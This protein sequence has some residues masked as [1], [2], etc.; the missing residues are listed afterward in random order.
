M[1]ELLRRSDVVLH[2]I[3]IKGLRTDVDASAGLKRSSNEGLYLLTRPTGGEVFKNANDL[4]SSFRSLLKRQEVVYILGFQA[5]GSNPGRFHS[6]K[7]KVKM[8]GATASH[9]SGYY[10]L[11]SAES[12]L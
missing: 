3:D 2:A 4:S 6:L 11:R 9:R 12:T 1:G 5:S 10:E 7:V 8:P